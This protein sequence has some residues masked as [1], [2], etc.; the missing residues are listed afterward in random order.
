MFS[1]YNP[2]PTVFSFVDWT[3]DV[4]GCGG[5]TYSITDS[6]GNSLD[7]SIITYTSA[8]KTF[9]VYTTDVYKVQDITIRIRG[10]LGPYTYHDY[11]CLLRVVCDVISTTF[12]FTMQD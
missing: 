4:P 1:L 10:I 5:F 8:T 9:S 2:S 7:T 3:S 6:N 11:E 12:S